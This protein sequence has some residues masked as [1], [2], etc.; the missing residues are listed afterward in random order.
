MSLA[1]EQRLVVNAEWLRQNI[2]VCMLFFNKLEQTIESAESFL[3]AGVRLHLLNNG[4]EA[5]SLQ[6]LH[7]HFDA[8]PLV[9]IADAGG[10]K[11]VSGGRNLQIRGT[12]EPWLLF[13]DNDI[14]V[15][16]HN[17]LE[18]LAGAINACPEAEI[19]VPRLFNKHE[20]AWGWLSD[21]VV[22]THGNCA[23]M[24]TER[25]FANAFPGGASVVA[26]RVFE[27]VGEYDEDLFVGFEDFELAI[28]AW[29]RGQPLLVRSV[30]EIVFVH[31]HRVSTAAADKSAA[32]VRY[33]TGHI[34]RSHAV[35]REKHGVLLDPNFSEWLQEQVKQ[36]TGE[37]MLEVDEVPVVQGGHA[38]H[39]LTL[40][41]RWCGTGHVRVVVDGMGDDLWMRLRALKLACDKAKQAGLSVW[42]ELVGAPSA[43]AA[44]AARLGYADQLVA[45]PDWLAGGRATEVRADAVCWCGR[46]LL[47]SEFLVQAV[48]VLRFDPAMK[49]A[50]IHPERIV[51]ASALGQGVQLA[52][53]GRFDP[54]ELEDDPRMFPAFLVASAEWEA[55]CRSGASTRF[56]SLQVAMMAWVARSAADGGE[57]RALVGSA[58][59]LAQGGVA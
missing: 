44:Q 51:F 20:D 27:R 57:H 13:V 28:R 18:D 49:G 56:Q 3:A 17:W 1:E 2:V 42:V 46:G 50:F 40:V 37:E 55:F 10:N 53:E 32:L 33:D 19:F 59:I 24:R 30:E 16:S 6:A 22:D 5:Q 58:V 47:T 29:K 31:D 52:R 54:L 26:R 15:E 7:R 12:R 23:F 25:L 21:F 9:T 48:Q 35:V 34:G 41:P 11:G 36:L 8:N 39:G 45:A 43:I 14:T 38:L 4:S